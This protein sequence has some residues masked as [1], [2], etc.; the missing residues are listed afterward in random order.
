LRYDSSQ[1]YILKLLDR[2]DTK[3]AASLDPEQQLSGQFQEVDGILPKDF[4]ADLFGQI[5]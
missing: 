1:S 5:N 2:G 4:S 3:S